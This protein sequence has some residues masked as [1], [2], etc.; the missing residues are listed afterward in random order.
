MRFAVAFILMLS[1]AMALSAS[2]PGKERH[3]LGKGQSEQ[4]EI[5]DQ[6]NNE[7]ITNKTLYSEFKRLMTGIVVC[8]K[9]PEKCCKAY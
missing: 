1:I 6:G 9:S 8:S 7:V 3:G 2:A 5:N 4:I